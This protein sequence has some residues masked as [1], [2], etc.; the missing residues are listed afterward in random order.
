M[1]A[2]IK[3]TRISWSNYRRLCDGAIDV[4][5]HMVLV[6]P[7]ASGKSSVLRA[8]ALCLGNGSELGSIAVRD[9][10][11]AD[12][13]LLIAVELDELDSDD[14]AAFP[15][16]VDVTSGGT[17]TVRVKATVDPSDRKQRWLLSDSFR[18]PAI[19]AAQAP[20]NCSASV[21]PTCQRRD[22]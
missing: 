15:D 19:I 14:R 9:F 17:V 22:R 10:T 20:Y 3:I 5:L 11:D 2:D 16:E 6:G 8:V 4:R 12:Q 21:S 13:P 1:G 18:S 7:N